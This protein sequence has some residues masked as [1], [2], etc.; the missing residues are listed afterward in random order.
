MSSNSNKHSWTD[1]QQSAIDVRNK[2]IL[3]SAAAGIMLLTASPIVQRVCSFI[4]KQS[5]SIS[6]ESERRLS[7]TESIGL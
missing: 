5:P 7:H 6:S 1:K 2:T 3:V 4:K